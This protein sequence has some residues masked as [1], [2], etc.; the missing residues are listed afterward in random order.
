LNILALMAFAARNLQRRRG[1]VVLTVVGMALSVAL[2]GA[3]LFLTDALR[4]AAARSRAETPAL[5]VQRLVAGRPATLSTRD[6]EIVRAIPGVLSVRPRVWGYLFSPALQGNM[7]IVG[8]PVREDV[9]PLEAVA[10][11]LRG[12][13]DLVAGKGEM[14]A[15]TALAQALGLREGDVLGIAGLSGKTLRLR[16]V[17]EFSSRVD[18]FTADVLMCDEQDARVLLGLAPDDAT[19]LAV[20]ISNPSEASVIINTL[21]EGRPGLR[22]IERESIERAQEITYGRRSGLFLV[23]CLPALLALGVLLLDRLGGLGR[24]E[25]REIA[26]LKAVGWSTEEVLTTR[27]LENVITGGLGLALGLLLAYVW[28]FALHAPGLFAIMAGFSAVMP[29]VALFPDTSAFQLVSVS[30]SVLLPYVGLGAVPAWRAATLDPA[31]V[32]RGN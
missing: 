32:M 22:V 24:E 16:F 13:R 26:V 29:E 9:P 3:A 10:G 4:A 12:G 27:I 15:G 5:I 25:Q 21:G 20:E 1:R 17:G 2:L 11:T 19:D 7:T 8:V 6:A 18:L 31:S 14:L 28:V 23:F 30:L